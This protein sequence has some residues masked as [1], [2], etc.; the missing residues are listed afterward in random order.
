MGG[1]DYV[2]DNYEG[3][4]VFGGRDFY[5]LLADMNR[6]LI[7]TCLKEYNH[8]DVDLH[9]PYKEL[10]EDELMFKRHIGIG[11]WFAYLEPDGISGKY[12]MPLPAG[13]KIQ[14]PVLVMEYDAWRRC[15]GDFP[16]SDPNQGWH[17]EDEDDD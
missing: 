6:D 14:S 3:Y 13:V 2:E 17:C 11:L 4:G 8:R 15:A 9:K 1:T 10:T 5:E 16:K 12:A 7:S